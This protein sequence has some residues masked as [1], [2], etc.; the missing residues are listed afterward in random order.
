[1]S[2]PDPI[3]CSDPDAVARHPAL[4][5][6]AWVYLQKLDVVGARG[7]KGTR[8]ERRIFVEGFETAVSQIQTEKGQA[9]KKTDKDHCFRCGKNF[10][11]EEKRAGGF[12]RATINLWNADAS[13]SGIFELPICYRCSCLPHNADY[14]RVMPR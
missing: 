7:G 8:R 12:H 4:K 1:M 10:V 11:E 5:T 14:E 3:D 6:S 2:L 9:E 13:F